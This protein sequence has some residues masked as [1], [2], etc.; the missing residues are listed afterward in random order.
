MRD[1][2]HLIILKTV[3]ECLLLLLFTDE[4]SWKLPKH[5]NVSR[6]SSIKLSYTMQNGCIQ[7]L[8]KWLHCTE[9]AWLVPV[10]PWLNQFHPWGLWLFMREIEF[11]VN[12]TMHPVP[13]ETSLYIYKHPFLCYHECAPE[14]KAVFAHGTPPHQRLTSPS[15]KRHC[16]STLFCALFAALN[17]MCVDY[18]YGW[19]ENN[20]LTSRSMASA[21]SALW[22]WQ[23]IYSLQPPFMHLWG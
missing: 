15:W 11:L 1:E 10:P 14:T 5:L 3:L 21:E 17:Y 6:S 22:L 20:L 9:T 16:E 23:D 13:A 19:L 4:V 12:T 18:E 8:Y 7:K 2:W